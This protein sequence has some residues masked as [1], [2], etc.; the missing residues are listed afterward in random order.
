MA[1]DSVVPIELDPKGPDYVDLLAR[2]P[3]TGNPVFAVVGEAIHQD[4]LEPNKFRHK[5]LI[6]KN[7]AM[8]QDHTRDR[9]SSVN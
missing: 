2:L 5:N 8:I 3:S 1:G 9:I 4:M 6:S 7:G